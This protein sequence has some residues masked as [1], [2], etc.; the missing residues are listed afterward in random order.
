MQH[1]SSLLLLNSWPHPSAS[2][3]LLHG[4]GTYI[5]VLCLILVLVYER[6]R[7]AC[8]IFPYA[9]PASEVCMR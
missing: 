3:R 6:V 7:G 8:P 5:H 1:P 4:A 9:Y 2:E